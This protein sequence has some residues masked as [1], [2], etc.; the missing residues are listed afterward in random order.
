MAPCRLMSPVGIHRASASETGGG[1]DSFAVGGGDASPFDRDAA[2]R[3]ARS[4]A[5]VEVLK[6]SGLE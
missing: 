1:S 2:H 5:G 4:T 6:E 3:I